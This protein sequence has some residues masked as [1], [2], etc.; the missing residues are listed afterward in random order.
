MVY[1]PQLRIVVLTESPH[2]TAVYRSVSMTS[3]E[4]L[5][6]LLV[7]FKANLTWLTPDTRATS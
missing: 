7:E 3:V 2:H 1:R 6:T 5:L 4:L